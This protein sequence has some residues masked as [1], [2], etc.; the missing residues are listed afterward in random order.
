ME[1]THLVLAALAAGGQNCSFTPV[2]VQK[3]FFLVDRE[4]GSLLGGPHFNFV[5]YDY[6]PFDSDVYSE[7]ESLST[8]GL[9]EIDNTMRY[10]VYRLTPSGY[11]AGVAALS[12]VVEPARGF[13]VEAANWVKSLSFQQ[14]VAAI[15]AKY[16]E[17]KTNS[18]FKS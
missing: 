8:E 5:P 10:R 2:Q 1:R 4:A 12:K 14:L 9:S 6:G 15:Y 13:L 16:P 3:L 7:I 17:M 18:I 11:E